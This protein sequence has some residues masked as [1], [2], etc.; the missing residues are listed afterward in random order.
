MTHQVDFILNGKQV[1]EY[2]PR[3]PNVNGFSHLL[4]LLIQGK[5]TELNIRPYG[6]ERAILWAGSV[7]QKKNILI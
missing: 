4:M 2:T 7:Q 5:I 3:H 6:K 1:T